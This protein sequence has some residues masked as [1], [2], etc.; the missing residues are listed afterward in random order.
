MTVSLSSIF[1]L[2]FFVLVLGILCLLFVEIRGVGYYAI[3]EVT[4]PRVV[5]FNVTGEFLQY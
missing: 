2:M 1:S 4:R 3:A 5:F